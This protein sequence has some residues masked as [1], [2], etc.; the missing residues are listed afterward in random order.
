LP[1][2]KKRKKENQQH[3]KVVV[4]V[5]LRLYTGELHD[6]DN[7][8]RDT[9][10]ISFLRFPLFF[11]FDL[12]IKKFKFYFFSIDGPC[13]R[14]RAPPVPILKGKQTAS[15]SVSSPRVYKGACFVCAGAL[16]KVL[17]YSSFSLSTL[18]FS[19]QILLLSS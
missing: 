9:S 5:V 1:S 18:F 12:K 17:L 16:Y 7:P 6:A 11:F 15:G 14:A 10:R 13:A 8:A 2:Q 3:F 4:V 19:C